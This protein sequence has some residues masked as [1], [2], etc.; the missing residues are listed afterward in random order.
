MSAVKN[1][2]VIFLFGALACVLDY[3]HN[4]Q[5][6]RKAEAEKA[7]AEKASRH[8]CVVLVIWMFGLAIYLRY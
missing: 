2:S 6:A 1:L 8:L 3:A 5:N 7:K 4:A